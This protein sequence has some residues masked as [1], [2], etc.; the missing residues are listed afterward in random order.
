MRCL[1]LGCGTNFHLAWVNLDINPSC[2][3]VLLWDLR[4]G[5]PFPDDSFDVVYHSHLLEHLHVQD[6]PRFMSECYRVLKPGG[7]IRVAVPD[8]EAITR[9]YLGAL[10]RIRHGIPN[11]EA[12]YDWMMLELYDQAVR[13]SSGGQMGRA[14]SQPGIRDSA[15]VRERIGVEID[16]YSRQ[17]VP[18]AWSWRTFL[19][20]TNLTAFLRRQRLAI[21]SW[22][23]VMLGGKEEQ[24][25]LLD[26]RFRRLGEVHMWMYDQF[27]LQR[28]LALAGFGE[29][30]RCY[31]DESRIPD[32]GD[33]EL[34]VVNG[35]IRK[36]DSLYMEA[37]KPR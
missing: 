36:P 4:R 12:E 17:L 10:E 25:A 3:A 16:S 22:A 27:S 31:A 35:R 30:R 2:S 15:F 20:P 37:L 5:V 19:Q 6:A 13:T 7:I 8:L 18:R 1:N 11:A 24:A 26:G 9:N 28:M 14:L 34:D 33:Y 21:V 23:V 32:L 29:T